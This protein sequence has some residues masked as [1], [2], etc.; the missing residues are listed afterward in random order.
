MPPKRFAPGRAVSKF[1][2]PL[3]LLSA[4]LILGVQI[5]AGR[6]QNF[7]AGWSMTL[8]PA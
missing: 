7:Y 3:L 8:E 6:D 1:I 5:G 2:L 4:P